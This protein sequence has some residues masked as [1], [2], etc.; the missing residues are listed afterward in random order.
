MLKWRK[1]RDS[2]LMA[3]QTQAVEEATTKAEREGTN[4]GTVYQEISDKIWLSNGEGL[5][6]VVSNKRRFMKRI[7][8]AKKDLRGTLRIAPFFFT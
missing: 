2:R 5:P 1:H 3:E 6:Y 8:N 7:V 4:D